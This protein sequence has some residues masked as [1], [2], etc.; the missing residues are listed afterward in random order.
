MMGPLIF[1]GLKLNLK[2]SNRHPH[3]FMATSYAGK[4]PWN[5]ASHK[6]WRMDMQKHTHTH[7]LIRFAFLIR[8][9]AASQSLCFVPS[10]LNLR[11][12]AICS[13]CHDMRWLKK[14]T[15]WEDEE[16]RIKRKKRERNDV[17]ALL[18]TENTDICNCNSQYLPCGENP[19]MK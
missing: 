1:K 19:S 18:A 15:I 12:M 5:Q 14:I 9:R 2:S 13:L 16:R 17:A 3:T 8:G 7:T 11:L 6:H 4:Q 10:A